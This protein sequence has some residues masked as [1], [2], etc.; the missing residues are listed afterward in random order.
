MPSFGVSPQK[1]AEL[2]RRIGDDG[3]HFP[4][5][6]AVVQEFWDYDAQD[7]QRAVELS[8]QFLKRRQE[9]LAAGKRNPRTWVGK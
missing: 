1:E 4:D 7:R 8:H 3:S 6:E 5:C 2:R 9:E